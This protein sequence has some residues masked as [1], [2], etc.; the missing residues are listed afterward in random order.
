MTFLFNSKGR[1]IANFDG[2]QLYSPQGQN[3]GH[4]I[5]GD[6]IFIDMNGRYMGEIV[7]EDHLMYNNHS[8]YR[9][10]N[11]GIYGNYG[12]VGNYGNPGIY[13]SIS[14]PAGY[15]DLEVNW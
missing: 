6:E 14:R 4:Y 13:S 7:Y 12:N 3:I 5:S 8:P 1:H 9:S 10:T 11:Y 15:V 2:E